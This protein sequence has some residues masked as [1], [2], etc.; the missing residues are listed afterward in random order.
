[1]FDESGGNGGNGGGGF[2]GWFN[3]PRNYVLDGHVPIPC[4]DFM[5]WAVW[6]EVANRRVAATKVR[7]LVVSTVFV[8]IDAAYAGPP[9][10]FETM[11]FRGGR[12]GMRGRS[13]TWD[14]ALDA[15]KRMVKGARAAQCPRMLAR[16]DF[17]YRDMTLE[18]F[19]LRAPIGPLDGDD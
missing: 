3:R 19:A 1:M 9:Q 16:G 11:L 4:D 13:C 14:E 15:H 10:L 5:T 7:G 12:G 18:I 6:F 8:G 2:G 17:D